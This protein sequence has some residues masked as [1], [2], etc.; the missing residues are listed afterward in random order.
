MGFQIIKCERCEGEIE[1]VGEV[2][3]LVLCGKCP[4]CLEQDRNILNP[5]NKKKE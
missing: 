2:K 3:G 1:V 4:K 5:T